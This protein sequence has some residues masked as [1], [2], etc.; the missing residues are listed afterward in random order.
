MTLGTL[1]LIAGASACGGGNS[2]PATT[3]P[4]KTGAAVTQ[5]TEGNAPGIPPL[6][7]AVEHTSSGL[8]YIDEQPGTGASPQTGQSVTV[9]YTG[10]LTTGKKFDSSRDHGDPFEFKLGAGQ[11]IRGWDQGVLGMKVGGTRT[12]VIPSELGY[13]QR[14]AG[15]VIP[16]NAT[17]LF[18]V[19]LLAVK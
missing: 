1:A 19:E 2:A 12:L 11:V 5:Q 17:L 3:S 16:P 18:D 14:G 13:G 4:T 15:G 7:G 10:W 9:Q 6:T 8:G